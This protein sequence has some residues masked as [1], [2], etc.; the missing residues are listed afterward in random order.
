MPLSDPPDVY[1]PN[2]VHYIWIDHHPHSG[3]LGPEIIP[4]DASSSKNPKVFDPLT[5]SHKPWAPFATRAD[6][7]FAYESVTRRESAPETAERLKNIRTEYF[8][9][10]CCNITFERHQDVLN[11]LEYARHCATPVS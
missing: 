3:R 10:G 2:S 7:L 6:F 11:T 4:L 1:I 5:P 9:G 8:S